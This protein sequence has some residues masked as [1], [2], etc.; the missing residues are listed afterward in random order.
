MGLKVTEDYYYNE[1]KKIADKNGFE[2][3][4]NAHRICAFRARAS[5]SLDVCPCEQNNPKRFCISELCKED[6]EKFGR[7]HCNC[8]C[9]KDIGNA[10]Y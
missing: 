4:E 8:Y 7:C 9:K 5:I 2:L 1:C 6:I 10:K 3:T